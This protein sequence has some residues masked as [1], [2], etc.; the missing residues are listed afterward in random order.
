MNKRTL[1]N[2]AVAGSIIMYDR[3]YGG[4]K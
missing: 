4:K 2:V 3:H 1:K